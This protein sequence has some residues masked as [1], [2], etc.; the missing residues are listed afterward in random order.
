M[1]RTCAKSTANL[2]MR[3]NLIVP[4]DI[5][6]VYGEM[7]WVTWLQSGTLWIKAAID[8]MHAISDGMINV[9]CHHTNFNSCIRI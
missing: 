2:K 8:C 5:S 4:P 9:E 7:C 6:T 1:Y 3:D